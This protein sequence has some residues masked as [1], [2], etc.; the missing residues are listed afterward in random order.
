MPIAPLLL[1]QGGAAGRGRLRSRRWFIEFWEEEEEGGEEDVI[2]CSA[3]K[4]VVLGKLLSSSSLLCVLASWF[5]CSLVPD[6]TG[7][8]VD[9]DADA[10]AVSSSYVSHG[11]FEARRQRTGKKKS[12]WG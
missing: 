4:S 3:I 8:N 9:A 6:S 7:N 11:G 5:V 2:S 1:S 12:V 10:D